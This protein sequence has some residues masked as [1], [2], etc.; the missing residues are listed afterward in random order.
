MYS[1]MEKQGHKPG[2]IE[3]MLLSTR[4][5]NALL[6]ATPIKRHL[7]REGFARADIEVLGEVRVAADSPRL[8]VELK[9]RIGDIVRDY[10]SGSYRVY[11]IATAGY[12]PESAALASRP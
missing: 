2:D 3:A 12:K 6:S 9:S 4:T 11:V 5:C 10:K 1:L 8:L 7:E